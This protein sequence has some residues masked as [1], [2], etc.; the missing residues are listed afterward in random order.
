MA[1]AVEFGQLG[2]PGQM[3]CDV[4]CGQTKPAS[5]IAKIMALLPT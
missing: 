1:V 2:E 3:G 5:I 4:K